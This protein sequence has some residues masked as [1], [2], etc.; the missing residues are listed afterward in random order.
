MG[1]GTNWIAIKTIVIRYNNIYD[2]Y[3]ISHNIVY[4]KYINIT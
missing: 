3:N 4:I 2:E 1:D